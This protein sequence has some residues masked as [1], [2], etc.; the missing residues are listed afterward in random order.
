MVS[1][2]LFWIT[3]VVLAPLVIVA[4][5]FM[6]FEKPEMNVEVKQYASV[7]DNRSNRDLKR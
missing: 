1:E 2:K 3:C 7:I 6:W 5:S 4:G